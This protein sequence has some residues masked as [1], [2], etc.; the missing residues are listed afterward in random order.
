[1]INFELKEALS[2]VYKIKIFSF[3]LFIWGIVLKSEYIS[4]CYLL[5]TCYYSVNARPSTMS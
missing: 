5:L 2:L 1:M 3:K 4:L